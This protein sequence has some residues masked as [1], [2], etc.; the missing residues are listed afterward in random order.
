MHKFA[1]RT[2]SSLA[3]VTVFVAIAWFSLGSTLNVL[4][5]SA[6]GKKI[7][8]VVC[9]GA[10]VKKILVPVNADAEATT[11][12]K[13]CGNAP[14]LKY[15]ALPPAPVHLHFQAPRTVASWQWIP[16]P[17]SVLDLLEDN[18]PPPGR[19]PP[20]TRLA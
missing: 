17:D 2:F 18:K 8:M 16:E 5:A 20:A 9:S 15:L 4:M 11:T 1:S 13:H 10:G 6:L 14:F 19:A 3:V 12:I 7:E